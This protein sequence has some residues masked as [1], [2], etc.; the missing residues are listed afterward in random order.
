MWRRYD[1]QYFSL[2]GSNL[3]PVYTNAFSKVCVFVVNENASIDSRAHYC[4]DAFSTVH[5]KTFENDNPVPRA[6]L[7]VI[8]RNWLVIL[9]ADQKDRTIGEPDCENVRITRCDV[10]WTLCARYKHTRL[11]YFRSS[12]SFWCVFDLP[13]STLI[14]YAF[15]FWSTFNSVFKSM[16]FRWKCSEY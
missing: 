2:K 1:F 3:G 14:R 12:Y 11:R 5:T 13:H 7:T 16:R 8:Q 9:V 4:S 15:W 10:S 6:C